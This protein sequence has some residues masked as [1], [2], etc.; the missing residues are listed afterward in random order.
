MSDVHAYRS[1]DIPAHSPAAP[2][3]AM[4][5]RTGRGISVEVAGAA[6]LADVRAAW[7][8]LLT[9]ADAPNVFM[10][11]ALVRVAAEADPATSYRALLAWKS[12]GGPRQLAGVWSFAVGRA[13]NSVLPVR[14]LTASPYV[15]GYLATPVID[16]DCLDETF[17]AMLDCIAADPKL[18]N[19]AVLDT[20]GTDAPTY[21]ALVRVLAARPASSNN[22]AG[23]SSHPS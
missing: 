5:Q 14:L 17:E 21:D 1:D 11:P 6:Q 8:D 18:P 3:Q 19:I 7:A 13:R 23:R 2:A 22:P 9:R 10:D 16:R 15:H 4:L 12:I 20:I